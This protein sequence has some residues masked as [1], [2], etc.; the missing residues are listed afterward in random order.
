MTPYPIIL[1]VFLLSLAPNYVR[2]GQVDIID[3]RVEQTA[4]GIFSFSVTLKH[5]DAGWQHY[6]DKWE[7]RA[8]DGSVLGTRVLYHPHVKEQ[9]FTRALSGVKI[10]SGITSVII[11]AHDSVHGWAGKTITLT[12]PRGS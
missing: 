5:D 6:A 12:I 7:V 2:A 11:R 10:P 9:P 3:A 4:Q 1:V 8:P